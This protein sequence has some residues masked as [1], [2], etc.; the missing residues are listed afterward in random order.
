MGRDVDADG[1]AG[2]QRQTCGLHGGE[3]RAEQRE[4]IATSRAT[5]DDRHA[6]TGGQRA[7]EEE[8]TRGGE[9]EV[10]R[11]DGSRGEHME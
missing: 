8:R 6:R 10:D 9:A 2:H 5:A 7:G 3:R 1:P 4:A 11:G